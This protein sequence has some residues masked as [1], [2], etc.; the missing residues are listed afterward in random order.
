MGKRYWTLDS[1]LLFKVYK[2][3]KVNL[4]SPV[5]NGTKCVEWT[6]LK[7]KDGYGRIEVQGINWR[8]TRFLL[9]WS[10]GKL[11]DIAMHKCDNPP[12]CNIMHLRW[13]S[14]QQNLYD[15]YFKGRRKNN[16]RKTYDWYERNLLMED[17]K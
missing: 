12:C 17:K 5:I 11:G 13:G 4:H 8:V 16:L 2:K 1:S 9:F 6:G 3:C 14:Y 15:A 7:D 10:T